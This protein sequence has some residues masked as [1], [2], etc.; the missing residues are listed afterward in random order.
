M[1]P[2][3]VGEG[4]VEL[5]SRRRFDCREQR[6]EGRSDAGLGVEMG[7]TAGLSDDAVDGRQ[8][9][10]RSFADGL[11]R[12]EGVECVV[13]HLRRHPGAV[14]G[15]PQAHVAS[16]LE[17]GAGPGIVGVELNVGRVDRQPA[18]LC[19][20]V[21]AVDG[22]VHQRVFELG[23]VGADRVQATGQVGVQLDV[24]A[25]GAA[26]QSFDAPDCF[27]EID[28]GRRVNVL[29]REGQQLVGERRPPVRRPCRSRPC[30]P[31]RKPS[32]PRRWIAARR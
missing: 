22:E 21:P 7:V 10:P 4:P 25:Q 17:T 8:S 19:H 12:E 1:A 15:N 23:D 11:C 20:R 14:V 18:A 16:R 29:A 32:V 27:I 3:R 13:E 2:P 24:L 30:P 31:E 28:C 6:L 9:Q 5:Q 26:Q